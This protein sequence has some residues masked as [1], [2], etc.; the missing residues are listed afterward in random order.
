MYKRQPLR[1]ASQVGNLDI[2]KC[3][4]SK[5]V[6]I[7]RSAFGVTPLGWA[8]NNGHDDVVNYLVSQDAH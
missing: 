7:N 3:L 2:V 4:V 8:R 1:W 5:G 6:D